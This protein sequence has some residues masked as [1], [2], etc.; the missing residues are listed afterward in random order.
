MTGSNSDDADILAQSGE[1][2]S[3]GIATEMK[4]DAENTHQKTANIEQHIE[5]TEQTAKKLSAQLEQPVSKENQVL[6]IEGTQVGN[7]LGLEIEEPFDKPLKRNMNAYTPEIV[8][9]E[10]YHIDTVEDCKNLKNIAY[11]S[12]SDNKVHLREYKLSEEMKEKLN[13]KITKNVGVGMVSGVALYEN[14]ILKHE[15]AHYEHENRNQT[16]NDYDNPVLSIEKNYTTEQVATATEYLTLANEWKQCHEAGME[17][18]QHDGKDIPLNEMLNV[19]PGLREEIEKNGFDPQSEESKRNI[20]KL[21]T[22][23]FDEER[24]EDY[25]KNSFVKNADSVNC[26]HNLMNQIVTAREQ[27]QTI[28]DMTK[29]IDIGYG[30]RV[31]FPEDCVDL[32]K[33]D[34]SVA[35]NILDNNKKEFW[36]TKSTESLLALDN[37][38]DS[39]GLKNDKAKDAYLKEQYSKIINREPDADLKLKELMLDSS[40]DKMVIYTDNLIEKNTGHIKTVSDDGGKTFTALSPLD[41]R[42]DE[43]MP[44]NT[45]EMA[46]TNSADKTPNDKNDKTA[47]ILAMR[48]QQFSR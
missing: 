45:Q 13:S 6:D 34:K 44:D 31:D 5:E 22:K 27:E 7:V 26:V 11:F 19:Y 8:R 18:Y 10:A 48:Q 30:M 3:V 46:Q 17:Y 9:D 42:V 25:S 35:Q 21:S 32:F 12:S 37:Y 47:A 41:K 29:N 23:Y 40:S 16:K 2:V 14:T 33:P 1:T 15:G 4:S 38:M 24:L 39:L 43:R 28:S 20:I 36:S